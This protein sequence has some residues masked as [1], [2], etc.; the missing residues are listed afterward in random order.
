VRR[1]ENIVGL[2]LNPPEHA[3][4]QPLDEKSQTLTLDRTQPDFRDIGRLRQIILLNDETFRSGTALL[5]N[6]FVM[7]SS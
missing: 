2:Y 3:I 7:R 6:G 4:V 1:I 5:G